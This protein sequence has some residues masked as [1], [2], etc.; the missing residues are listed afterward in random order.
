M[1]KSR[2]LHWQ[3]A[4]FEM[5][6]K[7][8]LFA[9]YIFDY[10]NLLYYINRYIGDR[11]LPS[12]K[13]MNSNL[14]LGHLSSKQG[15][16]NKDGM[17]F[18][19]SS[20]PAPWLDSCSRGSPKKQKFYWKFYECGGTS[21]YVKSIL[22]FSVA[23]KECSLDTVVSLVSFFCEEP[24]WPAKFKTGIWARARLNQLQEPLP[25]YFQ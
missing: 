3:A 17:Y 18:I 4:C 9:F 25:F 15:K 19:L 6:Y 20:V 5:D 2:D 16:L 8:T 23:M 13:A 22:K 24:L 7:S 14:T 12:D 21:I 10:T 11:R 1:Y